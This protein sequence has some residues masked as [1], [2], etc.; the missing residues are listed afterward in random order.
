MTG[1]KM[2]REQIALYQILGCSASDSSETIKRAYREL[3]KE[4]HPDVLKA[5]GLSIEIVNSGKS[6]FNL[7]QDAYSTI[8]NQQRD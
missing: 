1:L 2:S 3:I 8:I 6:I 7:I 4:C 5:A